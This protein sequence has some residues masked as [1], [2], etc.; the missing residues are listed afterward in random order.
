MTSPC[1][2]VMLPS[3]TPCLEGG[4]LPADERCVRGIRFGLEGVDTSVFEH[5]KYENF[6]HI[7]DPHD[8]LLEV[9]ERRK[10]DYLPGGLVKGKRW[11]P[12]SPEIGTSIAASKQSWVQSV[13]GAT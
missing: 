11:C 9:L 5:D 3:G 1:T 8:E 7:H 12:T 2:M 10:A 6:G 13:L 4:T